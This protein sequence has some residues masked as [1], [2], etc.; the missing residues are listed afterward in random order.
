MGENQIMEKKLS[1]NA[2]YESAQKVEGT[3][4]SVNANMY[5]LYSYDTKGKP[6]EECFLSI[7]KKMRE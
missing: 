7:D 3:I 2:L 1:L 4:D 5:E 6:Y